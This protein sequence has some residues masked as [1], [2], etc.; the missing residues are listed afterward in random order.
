MTPNALRYAIV[1]IAAAGIGFLS[2]PVR[3]FGQERVR[4]TFTR[5]SR[6]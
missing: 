3:A 5:L 1:L 4:P 6:Y 2:A